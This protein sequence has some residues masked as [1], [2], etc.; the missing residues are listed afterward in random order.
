MTTILLHPTAYRAASD[1]QLVEL[2]RAGDDRAFAAIHDRYQPRLVGFARGLLGG[3]HHDAEEVVQDA[4]VRALNALR[5]DDRDMA[6]RAW[7]HTIVR[8]RALDVLRRPSRTTDLELH[9]PVLHDAGADP[10]ERVARA[11][12]LA[13]LVAGLKR[14]PERQR[15]ALVMHELGGA[16]HETI[17]RRLDVS[18]GGSKALVSR[19]RAG[20]AHTRAAAA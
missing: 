8:N 3:A 1:E 12:D 18:T 2:V 17:A 11:E 5:A 10:H 4:F 7:L 14:L 13:A 20:L 15:T 6:L 19:A 16:S 9:A